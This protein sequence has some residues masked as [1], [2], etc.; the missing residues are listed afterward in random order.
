MSLIS[1]H[2]PMVY[3][4]SYQL[5]SSLTSEHMIIRLAVFANYGMTGYNPVAHKSEM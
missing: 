5:K 2:V 3:S 4:K 1:S